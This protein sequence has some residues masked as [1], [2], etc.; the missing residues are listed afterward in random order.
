MASPATLSLA[1]H[2]AFG[3][4]L[5][6]YRGRTVFGPRQQCPADGKMAHV[7]MPSGRA[8]TGIEPSPLPAPQAKGAQPILVVEDIVKRFAT[9]DSVVVALDHVSLTVA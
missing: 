3:P 7:T 2:R 9:P 5:M 8:V 6:L 4:A 1:P